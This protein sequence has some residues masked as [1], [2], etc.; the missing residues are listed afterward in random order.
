[1]Q[2]QYRPSVLFWVAALAAVAMV[3]GGLGPWATTLG[4]SANGT[5]GDGWIVIVAGGLVAVGMVSTHRRC[6]AGKGTVVSLLLVGGTVAAMSVYD[7]NHIASGYGGTYSQGVLNP[8]WGIYL[9]LAAGFALLIVALA[10]L[11]GEVMLEPVAG[12]RFVAQPAA[13]AQPAS[14]SPPQHGPKPEHPLGG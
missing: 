8:G 2:E 4:F 6:F 12:Y 1:M 5:E 13:P 3:V 14:Q 10:V 11:A 9:S 7:I